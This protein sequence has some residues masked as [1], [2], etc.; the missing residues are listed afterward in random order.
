MNSFKPIILVLG[1]TAGGKTEFAIELAMK[2]P[3]GGECICA[4]SMQ[5]YRKMDIGTAKPTLHEQSQVPHHLFDLVEPDY[6][7]FS[8]DNWLELAEQTIKDIRKRNCYPII[9]GGTNLYIQAL[10]QGLFDGP[11]PDLN[12]RANLE[13]LTS[14]ELREQLLQIDPPAAERIHLNDRKRTIRAIEVQQ[15]TGKRISDL[16]E[17]WNGEPNR[18]DLQIIGLD[19]EVPTINS[20]INSRVKKMIDEGLLQEV[21]QLV[22]GPGISRQAAE[23]L[24]YRQILEHLSGKMSL[25]EAVEQIKI[26]TRRFAKQQRTWLRRFRTYP[27]STWFDA[28]GISLQELVN[29]ALTVILAS[30]DS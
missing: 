17:Q 7:G 9:V 25:D 23:A 8:V 21:K 27:N 18:N 11:E 12:L 29:K 30:T 13:A 26:R 10:L 2:L 14:Q 15:L 20:R 22:D 24:G 6:E 4:D 19:Y 3:G 1:P 16:Q 5:V 28:G